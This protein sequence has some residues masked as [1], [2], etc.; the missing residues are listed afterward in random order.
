M[1][2]GKYTYM[3][4]LGILLALTLAVVGAASGAEKPMTFADPAQLG[5]GIGGAANEFLHPDAAFQ[6]SAAGDASGIVTHWSI[7]AGYY[8]YRDKIRVT[9]KDAAKITLGIVDL[10]AG[11][12]IRDEYFGA[13]TVIDHDFQANVPIRQVMVDDGAVDLVVTYQG[14]AYAGLCYP[15]VT[16]EISAALNDVAGRV[17]G[18]VATRDGF[19]SEQE[20]IRSVLASKKYW[21]TILTFF[22]LGLLLTFTPCVLPMIPI[23]SGIIIGQGKDISTAKAFTL[24]LTYVLAMAVT[25]TAMGVIVGLSGKNFQAWFQNPWIISVLA[26]LFVLLALSMF[27]FYELRIPTVLR[28]RLGAVGG[29]RQRGTY[30][31]AAIMGLLS[32][33]IISPCVT[34]PLIGALTYVAAT[35]DAWTGGTALLALSLG[36]GAPLLVIGTSAGKILPRTGAWMNAVKAVFGVLLLALAIWMLDRILPAPLILLL[37]GVLLIVSAIYMGALDDVDKTASGWFKL[38]KGLGLALLVYGAILVVGAATGSRSLL[39]PLQGL[40]DQRI[41][42]GWFEKTIPAL[43]FQRIKGVGQLDAAVRQAAT[44]GRPVMLDVYADWCVSCKEMEAFTFSDAAV[45]DVLRD[46]VLLQA[47]VTDNDAS[48]QELL[49]ALDLFG[50]SVVLFY[51]DKGNEW[52]NY[53]VVG[54]MRAAKFTAH[55]EGFRQTMRRP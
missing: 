24:S 26:G 33:L 7:A 38:W 4:S 8:L 30:V 10:P 12:E 15:P 39:H 37:A 13:T 1:D 43:P 11:K 3:K 41:T 55:V 50:P 5:G 35:G 20:R 28:D 17:S 21:L 48:D 46:F 40:G 52:R 2:N 34:A 51:D 32:A 36:M 31:G 6:V 25:Y 29:G 27:G 49:K 45:Q 47:D 9:P 42:S 53:R 19:Q 18:N 14:C 22:G 44:D 54:F 23:L 16:K